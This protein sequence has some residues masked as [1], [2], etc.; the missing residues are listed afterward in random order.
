M[1]SLLRGPDRKWR[2]PSGRRG[3]SK[4]HYRCAGLP[5]SPWHSEMRFSLHMSARPREFHY[6][7]LRV[8]SNKAF[9]A[10]IGNLSPR[11]ELSCF[12][13]TSP[14]GEMRKKYLNAAHRTVCESTSRSPTA[15]LAQLWSRRERVQRQPPHPHP[16]TH[17]PLYSTTPPLSFITGL[18][19]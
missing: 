15:G 9:I 8:G 17:P 6:L 5:S 4:A 12:H 19:T 3:S 7:Y 11:Q 10:S 13:S 16:P 18:F 1:A 2:C 14:D